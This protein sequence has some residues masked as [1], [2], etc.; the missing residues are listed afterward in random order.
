M[1]GLGL[2]PV[3]LPGFPVS[4]LRMLLKIPG[5]IPRKILSWRAGS[6]PEAAFSMRQ[7]IVMNRQYTEIQELNGKILEVSQSL[8]I[9]APANEKLIRMVAEFREK[10]MA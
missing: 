10:N 7:D 6:A 8:G 5:S 1:R 4:T 3:D 2:Y 9:P